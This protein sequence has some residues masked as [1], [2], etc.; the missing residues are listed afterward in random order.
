MMKLSDMKVST[1]MYAGFFIIVL[2]FTLSAG[3]Q[4]LNM[5]KLG[6]MQDAGSVR[7]KDA[8]RIAENRKFAGSL[9]HDCRCDHQPGY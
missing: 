7:A 8:L 9:W 5:I 2:I 6:K 3:Y 4:I 1:K